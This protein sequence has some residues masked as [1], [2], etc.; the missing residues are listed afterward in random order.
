[1]RHQRTIHSNNVLKNTNGRFPCR[2]C[3]K[4]FSDVSNRRKHENSQHQFE[5]EFKQELKCSECLAVFHSVNEYMKH[6]SEVHSEIVIKSEALCFDSE[7]VFETWKTN[8]EKNTW[9]EYI[10]RN[11]YHGKEHKLKKYICHRSGQFISKSQN[12]RHIKIHGSNKCG[13]Y[14]P[15]MMEVKVPVN[16]TEKVTVTFIPTHVG[17]EES[18][19]RLRLSKPQKAE[20]AGL[21]HAGV[22]MTRVLQNINKTA[23]PTKRLAATTKKDLHNIAKSYGIN[24]N[25]VRDEDDVTSVDSWVKEMQTSE[26]NRILLY[27]L[28]ADKICKR[29]ILFWGS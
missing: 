19:G 8:V 28:P 26:N 6:L 22:P 3:S 23:S 15:S 20:I 4:I 7:K 16:Q 14:C 12:K 18:D 21:L 10:L 2:V 11:T 27:K 1:M 29:V 13:F 25:C 17:H 9:S 24:I 5:P